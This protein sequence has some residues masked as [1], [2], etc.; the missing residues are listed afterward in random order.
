MFKSIFTDELSLDLPKV[1]PFLKDWGLSHCDLRGRIFQRP[2]EG[3]SDEQL[4]EVKKLLDVNGIKVGCLQSSLAKVH[5]PD[6]ERL[7]E[8]MHKLERLI[9]ASEILGC[10]L[11]RS[12]FFW[13]P[14]NGQQE[15]LGELAVRPDVLSTV[16]EIF[17]PF[18]EKAKK[19]G[20]V[21]ALENCGCTKEE[22][23]AML[24][25]LDVPGWGFAWD[26]KNTWMADKEERERDFSAYIKRLAK[27]TICIHVKSIG[28]ISDD[29]GKAELIPYE[30]IFEACI[31]EGFCGP[32]SV[33]TH[34][35]DKSISDPEACRRILDV[36][37]RAWP[38]AASG[39]QQEKS[40]I[41]GDAI[42]RPWENNPVTFAVIGLGMGHN[43]ALEIKKTS[44][45]KL[46]GVCD[47]DEER[48]KR[49][50]AACNVPYVTD[51][52]RYLDDPAIEAVM[53]MNETGR[54][55]ELACR[56]LEA[57]KHVLLT[58][59]MDMTVTACR[60]MI[61]LAER[62]RRLLAVD[63]CRRVRPSVQSLRKA[64][65]DKYFGR[66]LSANVSLR[67][68][69][70]DEYFKERGG[71]RGTRD[72]DGGVLS[73]QMVHHLDELIYCF[74]MP[75]RVRCD[76]FRQNHD[77]EMED[78]GIAVWEY[79]SGM[80][81]NVYATTCYPQ[82][83]WYYQMEIHGTEGGY[84]HREGGPLSQPE[85]KW[86]RGK[87][88]SDNAPETVYCEWLNSMD[89]FAAALRG[90]ASLLTTAED[91]CRTVKIINAMYESAY[92]KH[93]E[94]VEVVK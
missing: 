37:N 29:N 69:R 40:V 43:R 15:K 14:P 1:I 75:D 9:R 53:I 27:R 72:L 50:S 21:L 25:A 93:G 24:D 46:S 71:W 55:A 6:K 87:S 38:S 42:K 36:I 33:E 16:M 59:P 41:D 13:Q 82:E 3:L 86:F 54:H 63:F 88:W 58:K 64:V 10:R 11:V 91:G 85:T 62:H 18:A 35:Y 57:G 60:R 19:A 47:I 83:T 17:L 77:I 80:I 66:E 26:P 56:A 31:A 81:V 20:L 70:D 65:S 2:V 45:I 22:C 89:N 73:N 12:F 84:I 52:Q 23:F 90:D 76:V 67:V 34:N 8:E 32:V 48:A 28:T 79:A 94:W 39:A 61:D 92:G 74:G 30:K 7:A 78:L 5:L 68:H 51:M 44:G 49:T 4:F